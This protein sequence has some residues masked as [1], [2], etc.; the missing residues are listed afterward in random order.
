[1]KLFQDSLITKENIIGN[2]SRRICYRHPTDENLCIKV[3]RK[4]EDVHNDRALKRAIK[5]EQR[6]NFLNTN[7]QENRYYENVIQKL[8]AEVRCIYPEHLELQFSEK[9]GYVLIETLIK[10]VDGAI[11]SNLIEVFYDPKISEQTKAAV[12]TELQN[13]F[14]LFKKHAISFFDFSANVMVQMTSAETFCLRI[15]DID[16]VARG[17]ARFIF[18]F[19]KTLR[20]KKLTRR[21]QRFLERIGV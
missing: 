11:P 14:E 10:N 16:P 19:S 8:P 3:M 6:W 18:P 1:M 2:G 4:P 20:R 15:S 9:Y 7:I 13:L 17:G 12:L 5:N 21:Y